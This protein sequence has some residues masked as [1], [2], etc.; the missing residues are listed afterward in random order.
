MKEIKL[1]HIYS[2]KEIRQ[3]LGRSVIKQLTI[4]QGNTKIVFFCHVGKGVGKSLH[5]ESHE[6]LN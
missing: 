4:S 3:M 5:K 1:P 6:Q 2:G